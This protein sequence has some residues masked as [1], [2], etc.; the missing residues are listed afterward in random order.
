MI[1]K[2]KNGDLICDLKG[3][4]YD[5]KSGRFF[6]GNG[7]EMFL[8]NVN[9][10][11]VAMIDG[12]MTTAAQFAWTAF[13]GTKPIHRVR[14]INGD[15][16][17]VRILNLYDVGLK[18]QT[19]FD[20]VFYDP[21]TGLIFRKVDQR[22]LFAFG[23][24]MEYVAGHTWSKWKLVEM[25]GHK[26]RLMIEPH[27]RLQWVVKFKGRIVAKRFDSYERAMGWVEANNQRF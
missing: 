6:R 7:K 15:L 5:F 25:L 12:Q 11:R 20:E 1:Y 27:K 18:P 4:R 14:A 17:D 3:I 8:L 19:I 23:R 13:Y 26:P 22:Q 10:R 2:G 24:T 9:G 16:N 21:A